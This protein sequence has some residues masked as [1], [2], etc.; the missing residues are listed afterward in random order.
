MDFDGLGLCSCF[1]GCYYVCAGNQDLNGSTPVVA[2]VLLRSGGLL[3]AHKSKKVDTG[4][5]KAGKWAS[6]TKELFKLWSQT[7]CTIWGSIA[8]PTV[9]Q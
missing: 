7:C 8:F 2:S 9:I 5:L 3:Q 6:H 4:D 1:G